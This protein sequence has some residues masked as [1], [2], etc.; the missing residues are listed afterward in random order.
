[1]TL[2]LIIEVAALF[3][4]VSYAFEIVDVLSRR[5]PPLVRPRPQNQPWVA[6]QVATYNE[7]VDIV[8]PTLESLARI[9]YPN[10]IVQVVDNNTKD[11]A[12]WEPLRELCDR[13][14]P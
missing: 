13:L 14:G 9:D 3:L 12:L 11:P 7:P 2:L 5:D 6:L 4:S 10:Y 8:R 1:S